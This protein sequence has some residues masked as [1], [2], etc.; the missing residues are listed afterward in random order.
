MHTPSSHAAVETATFLCFFA[1]VGLTFEWVCFF[2]HSH[3]LP[4]GFVLQIHGFLDILTSY[5]S[6]DVFKFQSFEIVC[7]CRDGGS[8]IS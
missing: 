8:C 5:F 7:D 1:S 2:F 6:L 4:M 3:E